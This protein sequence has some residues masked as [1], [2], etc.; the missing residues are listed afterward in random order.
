LLWLFICLLWLFF[1]FFLNSIL[2][3]TWVGLDFNPPT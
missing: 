2:L 3:Y 1:F